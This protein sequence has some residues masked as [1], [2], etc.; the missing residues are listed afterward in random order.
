MR[1]FRGKADVAVAPPVACQIH[2]A[3]ELHT[4]PC[5][6]SRH[7][8]G[9]NTFVRI[10]A[11]YF[12]AIWIAAG[13]VEKVDSCED[14]E[15][16]AKERDGVDSVCRVEAFEEDEG[17]D[18]DGSGEGDIVEGVDSNGLVS[19]PIKRCSLSRRRTCSGRKRPKP[20]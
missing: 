15:E 8:I 1:A 13:K 7:R 3:A 12:A 9:R 14:D 10:S 16:S 19:S 17:S 18:E 5:Q 2:A 11:Q 4:S 20:C 6:G